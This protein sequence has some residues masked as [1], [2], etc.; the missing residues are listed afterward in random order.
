MMGSEGE[1]PQAPAEKTK[2]VE[3]MTESQLASAVSCTIMN[4]QMQTTLPSWPS[5]SKDSN[6]NTLYKLD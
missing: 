5:N 2:F 6:T 4:K 1:I 3:D